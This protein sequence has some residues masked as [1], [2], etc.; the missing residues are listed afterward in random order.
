MKAETTG[1]SMKMR[2]SSLAS[3]LKFELSCLSRSGQIARSGLRIL[4]GDEAQSSTIL[5]DQPNASLTKTG[6]RLNMI[7]EAIMNGLERPMLTLISIRSM[8]M[9]LRSTRA[10]STSRRVVMNQ[11]HD[12]PTCREEGAGFR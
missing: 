11:R 3:M 12:S 10:R 7:E 1:S 9:R 8:R 2:R 5:M 6:F 4:A